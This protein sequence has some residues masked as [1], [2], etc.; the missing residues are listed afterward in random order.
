MHAQVAHD[1]L[2][3]VFAE[4]AVTAVQL[5]RLVGDLET[6]VGAEPLGHRAQHGGVT[7]FTIKRRRR[8]P[9]K[10]P[11]GLEFSRHIGQPELQRLE[12]VEPLSKSIAILKPMP[13]SPRRLATG[14]RAFSKITARVGCAFQPILRSLA[15]SDSP[16]VPL[17]TTNVE[18]PPGPSPPVRTITT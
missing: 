9:D 15:P 17:S 8:A 2:D 13:S 11:R 16:G 18:M 10:G 12:F 3:A 4:I 1:L 5:Q 6:D 14:T 7:V